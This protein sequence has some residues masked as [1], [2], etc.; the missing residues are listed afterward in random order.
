[1]AEAETTDL[2]ALFDCD[3]IAE[4][5]AAF[6]QSAGRPP[7]GG[8]VVNSARF[9]RFGVRATVLHVPDLFRLD[10][11][12]VQDTLGIQM[13]SLCESNIHWEAE[14]DSWDALRDSESTRASGFQGF[15]ELPGVRLGIAT[16][17]INILDAEAGGSY[18][19]ARA[20]V[21]PV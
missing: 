20:A 2:E 13:R 14:P 12:P 21:G 8:L 17:V 18:L 5:G 11:Q 7:W 19:A 9:V 16:R 6:N 1:M 4:A 15:V 3:R 10:L